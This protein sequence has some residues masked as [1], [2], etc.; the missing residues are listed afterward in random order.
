M[1]RIRKAVLAGLA[2]A[3]SALLT[4]AMQSGKLPGVPELGAALALGVAAAWA[5]WRVPNAPQPPA[6]VTGRYVDR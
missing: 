4:A 3:V 2:T 6:G 5:V 1:K